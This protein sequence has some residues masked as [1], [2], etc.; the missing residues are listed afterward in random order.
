MFNEILREDF[1]WLH[2]PTNTSEIEKKRQFH[3]NRILIYCL[4]GTL[5]LDAHSKLLKKIKAAAPSINYKLL[6]HGDSPLDVI[7]DCVD[8]NNVH[9]LAKIASK[10]PQVS[11]CTGDEGYQAILTKKQ[12]CLPT[13]FGSGSFLSYTFRRWMIPGKSVSSLLL[14]LLYTSWTACLQLWRNIYYYM[15]L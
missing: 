14:Q 13:G 8:D 11:F 15:S 10:I 5:T 1:Y 3:N 6:V 9:L 2:K 12:L 7:R 4:K